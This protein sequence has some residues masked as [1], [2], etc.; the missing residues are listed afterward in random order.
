MG[1]PLPFEIAAARASVAQFASQN[2]ENIRDLLQHKK[3]FLIL[4][5]TEVDKQK[6]IN[7]IVG[8]L[9]TPNENFLLSAFHLKAAAIRGI[10]YTLWMT[11]CD[12]V[13]PKEKILHSS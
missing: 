5:E 4:D 8:S 12:N 1:K 3:V 9:D 6:Y 2:E 11:N 7:V 10:F 13:E